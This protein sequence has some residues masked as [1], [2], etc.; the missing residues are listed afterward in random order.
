MGMILETRY[1]GPQRRPQL[2]R[3]L[4]TNPLR[5]GST[6]FETSQPNNTS[7]GWSEKGGERLR[8]DPDLTPT[9]K[10]NRRSRPPMVSNAHYL[11]CAPGKRSTNLYFR[12]GLMNQRSRVA[13][14]RRKQRRKIGSMGVAGTRRHWR[15]R[16][17][18]EKRCRRPP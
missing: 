11:A 1:R 17:P 8:S 14:T 15:G 4:R 6:P 13:G 3:S 10:G 7:G 9:H 2:R 16:R 18:T 12:L 5:K